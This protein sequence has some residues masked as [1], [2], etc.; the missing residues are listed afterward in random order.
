MARVKIKFSDEKALYA[1]TILVRIGDINYGNHVGNDA[2]LSIIHEAR[3]QWLHSNGYTELNVAGSS[4]IM[5]DVMIAYKGESFYGDALEVVLYASDVTERTFDLLYKVT[6]IR[7]EAVVDIAHAKT[8]MVCF[9]YE[10]R[11]VV[12]MSDGLRALLV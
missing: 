5:A 10:I 3:V 1:T 4:M 6:T 9:D 7:G 11:K 8:G 12:G 2:I